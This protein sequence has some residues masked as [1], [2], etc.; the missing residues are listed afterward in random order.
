MS[1]GL[2]HSTVADSIPSSTYENGSG[3]NKVVVAVNVPEGAQNTDLYFHFEAPAK[4]VAWAGFGMGGR[5][6][7]SLM[8]IVYRPSDNSGEPTLSPRI[9]SGHNMPEFTKD[10]NV[11]LLAGSDIANDRFVANF[12]CHNCR[13]WDGGQVD[14][15]SSNA[16][17]IYAIGPNTDLTSDDTSATIGQHSTYHNG[18][19]LNM[20]AATGINGVPI[21]GSGSS[22]NTNGG[23][24]SPTDD[25]NVV[26]MSLGM[27]FHG[28]VMCLTF[29]LIYPLGYLFLRLFERA[30]LHAGIQSFGLLL[31]LLGV[32]SGIA[33]SKRDQ[34]VSPVP[35]LLD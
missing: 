33:V 24:S 11:T 21:V 5:M 2:F 1:T 20:Q 22:N 35:L 3:D 8:F 6:D 10:V 7:G 4:N 17:F 26:I 30:W 27:I 28:V 23:S 16:P 9:A 18:W 19:S 12:H 13:N 15:T 31:T 34:I 29:A 25:T 32:I 14:A